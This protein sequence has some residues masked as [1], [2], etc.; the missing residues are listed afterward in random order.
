MFPDMNEKLKVGH[1]TKTWLKS[2]I[3]H[4]VDMVIEGF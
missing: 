2:S 1:R 3:S 4:V